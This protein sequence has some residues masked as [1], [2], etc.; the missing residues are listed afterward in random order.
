MKCS[1]STWLDYQHNCRQIN[2]QKYFPHTS[3]IIKAVVSAE[4]DRSQL[5]YL[6]IFQSV[7]RFRLR[8][9]VFIDVCFIASNTET[10]RQA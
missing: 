6:N 5:V 9:L 10:K 4:C 7:L 3:T 8:H 2:T 1:A